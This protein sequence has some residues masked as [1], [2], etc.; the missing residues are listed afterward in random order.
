M[1]ASGETVNEILRRHLATE[2][3]YASYWK[4]SRDRQLEERHVAACL[5]AHLQAAEGWI[6][7]PPDCYGLACGVPRFGIEVSELVHQKT[8]ERHELRRNAGRKGG[9]VSPAS[10]IL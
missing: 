1:D 3:D 6:G 8:V 5:L 4:F 7:D 10:P 9:P 2:R